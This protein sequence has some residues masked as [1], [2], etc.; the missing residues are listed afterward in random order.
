MALA[1]ASVRGG[2]SRHRSRRSG[3]SRY[4]RCREPRPAGPGARSRRGVAAC[5]WPAPCRRSR[6]SPRPVA[7]GRPGVDGAAGGSGLATPVRCRRRPAGTEPDCAGGPQRLVRRST[8]PT[9]SPRS[10]TWSAIPDRALR[11]QPCTGWRL[12]DPW[13][14][15]W[16]TSSTP[17]PTWRPRRSPSAPTTTW[18]SLA[19]SRSSRPW[20]S[21]NGCAP[22]RPETACHAA[23]V[24]H[25][26][27]PDRTGGVVTDA[28]GLRPGRR[29]GR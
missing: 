18:T 14:G 10:R 25:R 29:T 21:P 6:P 28:A 19:P 2:E 9:R 5:S 17:L 15:C 1:A 7:V 26:Q 22:P 24:P 20:A 13:P 12:T 8:Q 23:T 16:L 3:R 11:R 4:D 27:Q